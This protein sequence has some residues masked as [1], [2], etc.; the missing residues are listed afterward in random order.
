VNGK[1]SVRPEDPVPLVI[2]N[3]PLVRGI[4]GWSARQRRVGQRPLGHAGRCGTATGTGQAGSLEAAPAG[5]HARGG[6][7]QV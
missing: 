3:A 2:G 5:G 7:G 4:T 1:L 6:S